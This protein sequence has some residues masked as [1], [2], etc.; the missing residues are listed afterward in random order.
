MEATERGLERLDERAEDV[1]ARARVHGREIE[2]GLTDE[3]RE[4]R[5]SLEALGEK[6][7][8]ALRG[9]KRELADGLDRI[10]AEIEQE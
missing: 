7:G 1:R 10:E 3:R 2:R 4:V 5:E 6:S 8:D 9:A